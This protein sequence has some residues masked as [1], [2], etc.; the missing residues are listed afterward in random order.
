M[1]DTVKILGSVQIA[2]SSMGDHMSTLVIDGHPNPDSLCA[3]LASAYVEGNPSARLLA[4]RDVSFDPHMRW[5]YTRRMEMEPELEA[6]R[7]AIRDASHVVFVSPVWWRSVPALLKGF[8]DR[9]LLPQQ[10]Y[11]YNERGLPEGLLKG[12]SARVILTSDTP[13]ALQPLLPGTALRSFTHGTLGLCGFKPVRVTRFAP[14]KDSTPEQRAA[15]LE[16]TRAL[17][18]RE[19]ER[20]ARA[21]VAA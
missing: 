1:M 2:A 14:V 18:A 6:A 10:D 5:G 8:V 19:H 13:L 7:Q 3:A 11:R 15:W 21:T 9:A 12:R 16:R 17:G 20:L 4:L